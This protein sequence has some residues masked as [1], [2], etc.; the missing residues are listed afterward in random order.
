MAYINVRISQRSYWFRRNN[1][2]T[3]GRNAHNLIPIR[4]SKFG[5]SPAKVTPKFLVLNA[6]PLVKPDAAFSLCTEVTTNKIDVCFIPETWL[7]SNVLSSLICQLMGMHLSG[8]IVSM[9]G[10]VTVFQFYVER[11]GN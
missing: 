3:R 7:N 6:R 2:N 5:P 4:V 9:H 11:I 10:Q 1:R 8:K